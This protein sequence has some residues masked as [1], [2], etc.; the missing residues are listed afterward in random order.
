M[1]ATAHDSQE[2]HKS[3]AL[4]ETARSSSL[5]PGK[6]VDRRIG[7]W[8]PAVGESI[9]VRSR[10]TVRRGIIEAA[11][12]DGSGFWLAAEGVEPRLFVDL[13]EEEL[14]VRPRPNSCC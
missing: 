10:G 2:D 3:S 13:G 1:S 6:R 12:Y 4:A 11:M 7:A 8:L 14:E 9:E 5:L